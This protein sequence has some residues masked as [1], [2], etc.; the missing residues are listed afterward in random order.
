M[1]AATRGPGQ[2]PV[3]APA[4]GQQRQTAHRLAEGSEEEEH[5]LGMFWGGGD[6]RMVCRTTAVVPASRSSD[7]GLRHHAKDG[8]VAANAR[9]DLLGNAPHT[10]GRRCA[11]VGQEVRYVAQ[12]VRYTGQEVH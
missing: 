3:V 1:G 8:V 9:P 5:L 6:S 2:Q 12:E 10:W 11:K 4:A 7:G